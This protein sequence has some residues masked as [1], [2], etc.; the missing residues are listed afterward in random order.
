MKKVLA[1]LVSVT[2]LFS[3]LCVSASAAAAFDISIGT[4]SGAAGDT[5]EVPVTVNANAGIWGFQFTVAFNSD[6]L[7]IVS[8]T[9]DASWNGFGFLPIEN[10]PNPATVQATANGFSNFTGT[11]VMGKLTFKI[12]D[13]AAEGDYDVQA[14][15]RP[16]DC[17]DADSN[18]VETN[19]A[20]G[21]ITVKAETKTTQDPVANPNFNIVIGS[22][23]ATA[24]NTVEVPVTVDKNAGIWGFQ[25]NVHFNS[26]ALEVVSF[27]ADPSWSA[28]GFLPV[29]GNPNPATIQATANGFSNFTGTGT[30]GKLTFKVKDG[31]ANG[32][33][34]LT[35]TWRPNDCIDADS[36]EVAT[37]VVPG[38]ITVG[39]ETSTSE[40][41][42]SETSTSETSTSET[43]TSETSKTEPSQ[44]VPTDGD[45]VVQFGTVSGQPGEVVDVP[46]TV[47][48]NVGIWGF[49]LN[50]NYDQSGLEFV[51]FTPDAAWSA[52]G[53][54]DGV[55]CIQAAAAGLSDSNITGLMG[56]AKFK[57]KDG[58]T[59]SYSVSAIPQAGC[60]INA[61]AEDIATGIIPGSVSI[62][63]S[64]SSETSA[65]ENPGPNV[66]TD[67]DFV[68]E[69]GT[70]NAK[71]GESVFVPVT[72]TKNAG[73]W[74]FQFD[75]DYDQTGL[76]FVGF[77]ADAAWSD[78][79]FLDG[80]PCIQAMAN[81]LSNST[82]TGLLGTLEFKVKDGVADGASFKVSAIPAAGSEIDADANDVATGVVPGAVVIG[83]GQTSASETSDTSGTSGTTEQPLDPI[84]EDS[85][86]DESSDD[87]SS[88]DESNPG[89]TTVQ[90]YETNNGKPYED[91]PNTGSALPIAAIVLA[92]SS[93]AVLTIS[94]KK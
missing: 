17:I 9:P 20:N 36:N 64:S 27:T 35:S 65:T 85:S 19:V 52:F 40:T 94:R 56:I 4:V 58:A 13:T 14:A 87:E 84:S 63:G 81:G 83:S 78:F 38:K 1:I 18:E 91:T 77:K 75:L 59:G 45:F 3:I 10:N 42:T 73:I 82:T 90:T 32:D 72:V 39:S 69:F 49:Q 74:G 62:G 8:F 16:N 11:G 33:Y 28:L 55:P 22:A 67:G 53:F 57:I 54:L 44:D 5:V 80:V 15:W 25:F 68:V 34:A 31:V 37:N 70:V 66:P 30:M 93:A 92:V 86:V 50:F 47:T 71:A 2:L 41:S 48:K 24:G 79:S 29:E 46:V 7:E 12:K 23:T 26:D 43:S 60:N 89:N 6:A 51:S 21:K 76:E 61:N 88:I